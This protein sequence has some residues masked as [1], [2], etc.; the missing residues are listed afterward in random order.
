MFIFLSLDSCAISRAPSLNL[1]EKR[2]DYE[3]TEQIKEAL[4]EVDH[5]LLVPTR[6]KPVIADIWVHPHELPNGDYFRGGWI[7]TV[8][9][10]SYWQVE[11]KQESLLIKKQSTSTKNSNKR[12]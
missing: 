7:R 2:S 3:G 4:E 8:V 5:P 6:T 1:L 9:T 10:R 12:G 11:E